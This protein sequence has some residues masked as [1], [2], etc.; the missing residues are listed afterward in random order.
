MQRRSPLTVKKLNSLAPRDAPY[1]TK[2][3]AEAGL[4]VVTWPSG[5]KTFVLRYRYQGRSKKLTLGALSL[6]EARKRAREAR[7]MRDQGVDPAAAKQAVRVERKA[8]QRRAEREAEIVPLDEVATAVASFVA[9]RHKESR[10]AKAVSKLLTKEMSPPGPDA[11]CPRSARPTFTR[12]WTPSSIAPRRFSRIAVSRI[13]ARF[14]D[15]PW[16]AGLL[17]PIRPPA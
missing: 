4:Y 6:A 10:T 2:D 11:A 14:S 3:D 5:A 12:S 17:Q 15:G 1:E 16:P 9:R 13:C 8:A 7:L